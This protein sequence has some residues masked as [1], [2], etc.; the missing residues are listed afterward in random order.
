M[1]SH[2]NKENNYKL[3]PSK[4][5]SFKATYPVFL[6]LPF[7]TE[8]QSDAENTDLSVSAGIDLKIYT[9]PYGPLALESEGDKSRE[10]ATCCIQQAI[11]AYLMQVH[12]GSRAY[13]EQWAPG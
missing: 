7:V 6:L 2:N 5:H 13:A 8:S 10:A 4:L 1:S 12:K 9:A 3:K 11:T